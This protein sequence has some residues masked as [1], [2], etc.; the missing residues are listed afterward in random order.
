MISSAREGKAHFDMVT[1]GAFDATLE[2][3][4]DIL[5]Q[6]HNQLVVIQTH[7]PAQGVDGHHDH[8][9]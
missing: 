9:P 5:P 2:Q 8:H 4:E 3:L 1:H 7:D 6:C